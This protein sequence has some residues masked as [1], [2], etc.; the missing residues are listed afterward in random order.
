MNNGKG[1][2]QLV[3]RSRRRLGWLSNR[4]SRNRSPVLFGVAMSEKKVI[5]VGYGRRR[6]GW[7]L[8][9]YFFAEMQN[10]STVEEKSKRGN[11]FYIFG[12]KFANN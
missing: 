9:V 5:C 10:D 4:P 7:L 11:L 1:K 6:L 3:N 12:E 2:A 8:S